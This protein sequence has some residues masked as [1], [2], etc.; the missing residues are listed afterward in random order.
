MSYKLTKKEDVFNKEK[1][2]IN[3]N[4]YPNVADC[5]LVLITTEKGHNNEFVNKRSSFTYIVLEGEGSFYIDEEEVKVE[6]GDSIFIEPNT[7]IYYKGNLKLFL[8][9]TPAWRQEDEVEIRS[10]TW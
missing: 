8:M 6:K 7:K 5:G 9:T 1:F 4:V 3:L 2:G 10:F